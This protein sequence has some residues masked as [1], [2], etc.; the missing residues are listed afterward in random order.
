MLA[1]TSHT[2]IAVPLR[3]ANV[4]T[5]QICGAQFLKRITKTGYDDALFAE[6]RKD[7][8]FVFNKEAYR[9]ASVLVAGPSF[10][11]GSS[12][13]HAVWALHDYGFQVI[14]GSSFADIFRGNCG[15]QGPLLA[16]I[17]QAEV[18][19]LWSLIEAAP[20]ARI[21][22]DLETQA[23][24]CEQQ[25]FAFSIDP[26]TRYRLLKGLDE[27]EMTLTYEKQISAFES[28]R[29]RWKPGV[30]PSGVVN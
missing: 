4:D 1:F 13:E 29:P 27:V 9:G 20:G 2:G 21:T 6:W 8:E 19:K 3:R 15:K 25:T 7:P 18:E 30:R 23:I 14:V 5:D 12:R 11:T 22:V 28:R 16:T 17:P 10:G 24:I 26:H